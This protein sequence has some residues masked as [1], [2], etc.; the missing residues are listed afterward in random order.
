MKQLEKY[1]LVSRKKFYIISI[2]VIAIAEPVCTG[3]LMVG[4][5]DS[6]GIENPVI[7]AVIAAAFILVFWISIHHAMII[8]PRKRFKGRLKYF[9]N[10]GLINYAI[11]D[12]QY[13]VKK[14]DG[15]VL[16]GNYCIMGKGTGLIV[17]YNEISSMYVKIDRSTDDDGD[18][19]ETWNLKIDA[20]GKTYKICSVK[21]NQQ[22]VREWAEICN[23]IQLKA[24]NIQ[25]K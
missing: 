2:I 13:G 18:T 3:I 10:N 4:D 15:K 14:F 8:K 16:L 7:A 24:P 5:E 6:D 21:N 20:G 17:F 19:T 23:F 12:V 25:L 22:S 9:E 1:C 11:S